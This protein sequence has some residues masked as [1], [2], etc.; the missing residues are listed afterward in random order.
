[1]KMTVHTDGVPDSHA[2][3][4]SGVL[5]ESGG[6]PRTGCGGFGHGRL[7]GEQ[8]HIT[9]ELPLSL[10]ELASVST[11]VSTAQERRAGNF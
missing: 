3:T 7:R 6:N 4:R 5:W 10:A 11:A 1:M 2:T 8:L 9:K